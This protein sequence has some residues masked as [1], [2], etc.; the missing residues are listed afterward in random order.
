M[1]IFNCLVITIIG[2]SSGSKKCQNS[3]CQD[4]LLDLSARIKGNQNHGFYSSDC[5]LLY[6]LCNDSGIIMLTLLMEQ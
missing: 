3:G 1:N 4:N 6:L 2:I 5:V